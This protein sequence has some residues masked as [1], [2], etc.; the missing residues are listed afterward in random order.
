M[1]IVPLFRQ[2]L[3]KTYCCSRSRI[4]RYAAWLYKACFHS[5]IE[6]MPI[7]HCI[8]DSHANFF[9][10]NDRMQPAWPKKAMNRIPFIKSYRL[11]PV[12][13]FNLCKLGSTTMG[14]ENIFALLFGT[15]PPGSMVML[16]FGEI[17]CRTQLVRISSLQGLP[18]EDVVKH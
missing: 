4:S 9:S 15:I 13:A 6:E 11:G 17:D 3:A 5:A 16:C 10:G 2:V 1:F 8:G 7:I 12:L 14:R 18:I